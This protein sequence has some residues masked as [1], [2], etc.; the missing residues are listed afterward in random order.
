MTATINKRV[1]AELDGGFVVFL[2]GARINR[3][4]KPRALADCVARPKQTS[5]T[6][7]QPGGHPHGSEFWP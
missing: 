6:A 3:W 1:A 4:W 5:Q 7:T 2:I